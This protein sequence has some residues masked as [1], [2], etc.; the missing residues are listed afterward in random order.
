MVYYGIHGLNGFHDRLKFFNRYSNTLCDPCSKFFE[1][2][3]STY[4]HNTCKSG[5][6]SKNTRILVIIDR[7]LNSCKIH[8]FANNIRKHCIINRWRTIGYPHKTLKP[9]TSIHNIIIHLFIPLALDSD[10]PVLC[11]AK[12]HKHKCCKLK[13][14]D[15][16]LQARTCITAASPRLLPICNSKRVSPKLTQ[17][18]VTIFNSCI[19]PVNL[20]ILAVKRMMRHHLKSGKMSATPANSIEIAKSNTRLRNSQRICRRRHKTR[21]YKRLKISN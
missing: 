15:K 20:I 7:M 4:I 11:L 2:S 21:C 18:R 13:P 1:L 14:T 9:I 16:H 10:S 6:S 8:K 12:I 5:I 3:L 17:E 19:L